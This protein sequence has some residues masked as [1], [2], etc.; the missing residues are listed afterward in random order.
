MIAASPAPEYCRLMFG[1]RFVIFSFR[2]LISVSHRLLLP[3]PARF[4]SRTLLVGQFSF[5]MPAISGFSSEIFH[6]AQLFSEFLVC[7]N[8]P[9]PPYFIVFPPLPP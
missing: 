4:A 9:P 8:P 7:S 3:F 6:L 2:G 1:L 5:V